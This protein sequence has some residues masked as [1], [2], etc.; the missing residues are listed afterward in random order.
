MAKRKNSNSSGQKQKIKTLSIVVGVLAV[1][2]LLIG[3]LF[4]AELGQKLSETFNNA[5]NNGNNETAAVLVA[6][7]VLPVAEAEAQINQILA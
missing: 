4:H 2:G 5:T 3:L 6:D 1:V 7:G